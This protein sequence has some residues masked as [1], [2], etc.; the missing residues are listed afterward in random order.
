MQ[1]HTVDVFT[2]RRY[3]GNPLAVFFEEG[4]LTDEH[5][6]AIAREVGFVETTFV[7]PVPREGSWR[8]RI[9]TPDREIPFAGH[10][11]LGSA[12]VISRCL[13]S[14]CDR[15]VLELGVGDIPVVSENGR[16]TMDQKPPALGPVIGDRS[17]AAALLGL[18][19]SDLDP[20][21]V[22]FASTGLPCLVL[23]VKD[24]A[25]LERCRVDHRAYESWLA[26]VGPG[27]LAAWTR[28][29]R[30]SGC[31]LTVRVFVDDTGF[32][33]DPATGSAAGALAGYLLEHGVF[34][35]DAVSVVESQ[36]GSVGRLSRLHVEARREAGTVRVRVGGAVVPVASGT[37]PV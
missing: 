6:Q 17:R 24:A 11:T 18:E 37:W 1:F 31:D 33:E 36:G 3:Q 2:D 4:G 20:L 12:D 23:P 27:N 16:W 30:E 25:A 10:P 8:V 22:R 15:L 26:Q 21:P 13:G 34:G 29:S 9:F 14:G 5:R 28:D 7:D 32:R 35:R 19:E